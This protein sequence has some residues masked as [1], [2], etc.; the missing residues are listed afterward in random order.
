MKVIKTVLAIS[1]FVAGS[2]FFICIPKVDPS[3]KCILDYI[4]E[5]IERDK[6]DEFSKLNDIKVYQ[7][8]GELTADLA[9]DF[10]VIENC[11]FYNYMDQNNMEMDSLSGR[12]FF[13]YSVHS[14]LKNGKIDKNQVRDE[15][16]KLIDQYY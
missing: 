11:N 3:M 15:V 9:E 1:L 5:N 14:Y 2:T 4:T 7:E 16:K 8:W 10:F 6:L 12:M 13:V